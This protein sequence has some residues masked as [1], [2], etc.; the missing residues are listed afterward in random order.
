MRKKS[1]FGQIVVVLIMIGV[2]VS[3]LYPFLWIIVSTFKFERDLFQY[4]PRL[5]ASRYTTLNYIRVWDRI[6]LMQFFLNTL[7][8]R[9]CH[10]PALPVL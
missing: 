5:F 7:I 10:H 6:P 1:L 9:H 4:P 3:V 8:F 2:A